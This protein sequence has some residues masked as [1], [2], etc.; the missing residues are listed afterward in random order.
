MVNCIKDFYRQ[1]VKLLSCVWDWILDLCLVLRPCRFSVISLIA[2]FAF[3]GLAPQGIDILRTM[4]E[5]GQGRLLSFVMFYTC[6]WLWALSIWYWARHML[7]FQLIYT[8]ATAT[9][10]KPRAERLVE[11]V[12]RVLGALAFWILWFALLK[13][14]HVYPASIS[15]KLAIDPKLFAYIYFFSGI[16]FYLFAKFRIWLLGKMLPIPNTRLLHQEF[17]TEFRQM[18]L[19]AR[20]FAGIL[21]AISIIAL[22][23]TT[24]YP[25]V[26][27]IPGTHNMLLIAAAN[28]V[29]VGSILVF[30]GE[31]YRVPVFL[32]LLILAFVFS[33]WNDNHRIRTTGD[34]ARDNRSSIDTHFAEW[35]EPR[36]QKWKLD[37]ETSG[38]PYPMFL[39]AAEGG[40]IRAAYWTANVL[41]ALQDADNRF[42]DHVYAM[43]G[44]SGGSLGIATFTAMIKAKKHNS[45]F[46][47]DCMT[48]KG[49]SYQACSRAFLE[50]DFLAPPAGR[51]LYG[52][53]IQRF[54]PFPVRAF[55]RATAIE[56]GWETAWKDLT[57]T[58]YFN[59]AFLDLYDDDS[60]LPVL[61]LNSTWV[62][63]GYRVV[64]SNVKQDEHFLNL[65]DLYEVTHQELRLSTAVHNSARFTYVSPAGSVN[66]QSG[67]SWGHLV[68]G[69]YFENSGSITL[70][71]AYIAI[72]AAAGDSFSSIRP[73]VLMITNEPRQDDK[74]EAD[75]SP[76]ANELLSPVYAMLNTRGG[77][78]SLARANMKQL[79][80]TQGVFKEFGLQNV[81]GP[82]P[83]G[84][85]L[86]HAAMDTMDHRLACYI[87]ELPD[88]NPLK[89]TAGQLCNNGG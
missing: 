38:K 58:D 63:K 21:T 72:Q 7:R 55:D 70:A 45:R 24:F 82:V 81:E 83:L 46:T 11:E 47:A 71:E 52:D 60:S 29:F 84:W 37:P 53:L 20:I 40:G 32:M 3:F 33:A 17:I 15:S 35:L 62:E 59:E 44:V 5:T 22:F 54:L 23:I 48:D 61:L 18:P 51:M 4:T 65:V 50:N 1:P 77:R 57:A 85:M 26:A 73:V 10:N 68:D 89:M 86:S 12:P 16:L 75:P 76:I 25:T 31:K 69:G 64:T 49:F 56:Q 13:S 43:S 27:A 88:G 66:D 28:W 74:A 78:G 14:G 9:E 36:L 8:R 87:Q 6:I 80:S 67:S 30:Y 79:V 41:G 2:G 34:L 39:V 19:P 42:A